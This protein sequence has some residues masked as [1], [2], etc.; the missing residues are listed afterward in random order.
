M[1]AGRGTSPN[2][3]LGA[4]DITAQY[5]PL[6]LILPL[7]VP[8]VLT[9]LLLATRKLFRVNAPPKTYRALFLSLLSTA[10]VRWATCWIYPRRSSPKVLP[11]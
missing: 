3:G 1:P 8:V 11:P 7:L 9:I 5:H 6:S 10:V 2:D 4:V